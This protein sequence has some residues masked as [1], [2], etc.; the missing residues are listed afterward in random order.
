M[1]KIFAAFALAGLF[2]GAAQAQNTQEAAAEAAA[3]LSAAEDVPV[4]VE[5]PKYWTNTLLT[6]I[7]F[8]QTWLTQWAGGGYNNVSL[9]GNIDANFNYQ[10]DK[11]KGFNRIQMDYGFLWSADKPILQKN[12]DRLYI[13]SKWGYESFIKN[14]SYSGSF[15]FKTEF[16]RIYATK[17]SM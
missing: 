9:A 17:G 6:N 10:R 16:D 3:A 14:L 13:E 5:K 15:D 8:G 2:A 4:A 1:K 7:S 12:K 11:L